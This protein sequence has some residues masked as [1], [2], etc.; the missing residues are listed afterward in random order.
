MSSY[1]SFLSIK[2]IA[3]IY[4]SLFY[5][6]IGFLSSLLLNEIIPISKEEKNDDDENISITKLLLECIIIFSIVSMIFYFLRKIIKHI[7]YPL[8][9]FFGFETK[10]LKELNGVALLAPIFMTYQVNFGK[11]LSLIK[12]KLSIKKIK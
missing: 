8:E 1:Y 10:K 5:F 4:F 9:G 12:K 11:K 6:I 7:P 3:I 2:L